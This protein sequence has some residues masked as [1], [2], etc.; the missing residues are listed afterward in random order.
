MG[1]VHPYLSAQS[2]TAAQSP[3]ETASHNTAH[4]G[5]L[6]SQT[7]LFLCRAPGRWQRTWQDWGRALEELGAQIL[8]ARAVISLSEVPGD[9]GAGLPEQ[10]SRLAAAES[11]FSLGL[12]QILL[13]QLQPRGRQWEKLVGCWHHSMALH[14]Q[15]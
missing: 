9:A 4:P 2:L 12:G 13:L 1:A 11:W 3:G 15:H 7:L 6:P 8:L 5:V 10:L 14:V